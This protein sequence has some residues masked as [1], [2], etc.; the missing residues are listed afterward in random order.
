MEKKVIVIGAGVTGLSA[1]YKLSNKDYDVTVLEAS[2]YIGGL[3]GTIKKDNYLIDMGPHLF[4]TEDKD[5]LDFMIRTVGEENIITSQRDCKLHLFNRYVDYP[6][7]ARSALLQLGLKFSILSF[8]SYLWSKIKYFNKERPKKVNFE[9]WAIRSYGNYLY[10]VFFKPYTE[11]FWGV[12]CRD[13][14]ANWAD[15][16]I[17]KLNFIKTIISLIRRK[18]IKHSY[19]LRETLPVRYPKYGYGMIPEKIYEL[20]LKEGTKVYKNYRVSKIDV[21]KNKYRILCENNKKFDA[22]YLIVTLSPNQLTK[23]ISRKIPENIK[24]ISEKIKFRSLVLVAIITNKQKILPASYVHFKGKEY[25]RLTES[26]KFSPYLCP[27]GENSLWAEITCEKYDNIWNKSDPELYNLCMKDIVKDKFLK[28][29]DVK[30]YFV[31]R[32]PE[33]YPLFLLDF[34]DNRKKM[35]EYFNKYK[36]LF[37]VGRRGNLSYIDSDQGIKSGFL[38]AD[39]IINGG[40]GKD[41]PQLQE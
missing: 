4:Y 9:E 21:L 38:I 7:S 37:L 8:T 13:L 1:A 36:N 22:D 27:E 3:A 2:P 33:P 12:S 28:M 41:E 17:S 40:K 6:P 39:K 30:K 20:A 29:S 25:H 16:R 35:I 15:E 10:K 24:E 19:L 23:M 14:A 26:K 11:K 18:Y 5:I 31:I 32:I 34:E